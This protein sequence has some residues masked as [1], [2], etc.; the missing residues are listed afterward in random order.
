MIWGDSDAQGQPANRRQQIQEY[1]AKVVNPLT[2]QFRAQSCECAK[3]SCSGHGR[4]YVPPPPPL[5]PS[6][7]PSP[8]SPSPS[9]SPSPHPGKKDCLQLM[10]GLAGPDVKGNNFCHIPACHDPA[11]CPMNITRCTTCIQVHGAHAK[12]LQQ[13][14]CTVQ[15]TVVRLPTLFCCRLQTYSNSITIN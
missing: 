8:P 12:A 7:A 13:A 3:S 5:P 14:G 10:E 11:G 2:T 6:P 15:M 4:C 1:L 9:P